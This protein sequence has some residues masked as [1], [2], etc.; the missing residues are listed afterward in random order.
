MKHICSFTRFSET[1][2]TL[3]FQED[4][5]QGVPPVVGTLYIKRWAIPYDTQHVIVTIEVPETD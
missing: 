4:A 2:G 5:A 1:K 3:K